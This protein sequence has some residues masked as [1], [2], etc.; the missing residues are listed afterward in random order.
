MNITAGA[1]AAPPGDNSAVDTTREDIFVRLKCLPK[2][3]DDALSYAM[4]SWNRASATFGR[5]GF[6]QIRGMRS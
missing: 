4:V 3:R 5:A 2:R 6:H 1:D